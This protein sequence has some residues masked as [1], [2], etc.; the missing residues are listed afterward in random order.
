MAVKLGF[1]VVQCGNYARAVR[2]AVYVRYNFFCISLPP[3]KQHVMAEFC[4][5]WTYE[6]KVAYKERN[7]TKHGTLNIENSKLK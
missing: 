2:V 3:A 5:S 6:V 7:E 1:H 4:D